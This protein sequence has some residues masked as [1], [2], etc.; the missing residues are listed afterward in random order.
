MC[1]FNQKLC[2]I[3]GREYKGKPPRLLTNKDT[4]PSTH[5]LD[6]KSLKDHIIRELEGTPVTPTTEITRTRLLTKLEASKTLEEIRGSLG[7]FNQYPHISRE[8]YYSFLGDFLANAINNI[9]YIE[10]LSEFNQKLT[11]IL[12]ELPRLKQENTKEIKNYICEVL[13]PAKP[14]GLALPTRAS[15]T[16]FGFL[17]LTEQLQAL[18]SAASIQTSLQVPNQ[19]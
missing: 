7:Q 17:Y 11:Q 2:Q 5:Y 6:I 8:N 3:H 14:A 16:V 9:F 10:T 15:A 18:D 12:E 19:A 4:L 13:R 1:F